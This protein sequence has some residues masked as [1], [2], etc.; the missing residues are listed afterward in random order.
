M[1]NFILVVLISLYIAL[2]GDRLGNSLI[3]ALPE[4]WRDEATLL[5][6]SIGRSFGGFLRGQVIFALVY[7]VLNAV[8]MCGVRPELRARR[9]DYRRVLYVDPAGRQLPGLYS[10][11]CWWR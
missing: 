7:G 3:Q 5:G 4:A 10:R 11:R 2:D 8:I 9:L 1:F 6:E